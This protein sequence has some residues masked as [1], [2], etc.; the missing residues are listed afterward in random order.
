MGTLTFYI[1]YNVNGILLKFY[2]DIEN[3]ITN[4]HSVSGATVANFMT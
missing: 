3:V 2:T 4:C 1:L